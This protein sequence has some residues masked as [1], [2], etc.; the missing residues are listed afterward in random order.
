M[1]RQYSVSYRKNQ[2]EIIDIF[3]TMEMMLFTIISVFDKKIQ[4]IEIIENDFLESS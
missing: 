2:D 3:N 4:N 1:K